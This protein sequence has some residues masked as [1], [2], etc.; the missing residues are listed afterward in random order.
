MGN[1]SCWP[2]WFNAPFK[3]VM[4]TY[5][6]DFH[7]VTYK[8]ILQERL[9]KNN[10]E[11]TSYNTNTK[12]WSHMKI[13]K[14]KQKSEFR[15]VSLW[16]IQILQYYACYAGIIY[17]NLFQNGNKRTGSVI[18]TP[19]RSYFCPHGAITLLRCWCS[20]IIHSF[21]S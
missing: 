13:T 15:R 8:H 12:P 17:H 3:H 18:A 5:D 2:I 6:H 1:C 20:Q 7:I 10:I 4:V 21:L 14:T 11:K 9:T 19:S 16:K